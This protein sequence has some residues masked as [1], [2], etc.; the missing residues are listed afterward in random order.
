MPSRQSGTPGIPNVL[1]GGSFAD[2]AFVVSAWHKILVPH[3]P[4]AKLLLEGSLK[5]IVRERR[6]SK[7][8]SRYKTKGLDLI[9]S[10]VEGGGVTSAG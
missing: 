6:L 7:S 3:D 9:L 4:L 10:R 8:V 2:R 5:A 1:E